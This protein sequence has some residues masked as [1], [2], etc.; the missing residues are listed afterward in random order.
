MPPD[1]CLPCNKGPLLGCEEAVCTADEEPYI[2]QL[3]QQLVTKCRDWVEATRRGETPGCLVWAL[4]CGLFLLGATIASRRASQDRESHSTIGRS[5]DDDAWELALFQL[6][7]DLVP[8]CGNVPTLYYKCMSVSS[9]KR[10][11]VQ[12][13]VWGRDIA[14]RLMRQID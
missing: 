7:N 6:S 2:R 13:P 14:G 10:Q 12:Q 3:G 8:K 9:S 4:G 11:P 1:V 5:I